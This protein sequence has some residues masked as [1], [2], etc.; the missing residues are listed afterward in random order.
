MM[1]SNQSNKMHHNN[2]PHKNQQF[3]V[4]DVKVENKLRS[5]KED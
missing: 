3:V 5:N 1:L 4:E 2:N